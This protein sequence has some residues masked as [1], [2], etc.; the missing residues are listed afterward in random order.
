M[1]TITKSFTFVAAQPEVAVQVQKNFQEL[2]DFINSSVATVDSA[3]AYTACPTLPAT[4]PTT[5]EQAARKTWFDKRLRWQAVGAANYYGA[6]T[7]TTA[8]AHRIIMGGYQG[9]TDSAGRI[10]IPYGTTLSKVLTI[11][12]Q[13]QNFTGGSPLADQYMDAATVSN[14]RVN[15]STAMASRVVKVNFLVIGIV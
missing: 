14:F 6:G 4:D 13:L 8:D 7:P 11:V 2:I 15:L 3:K 5:I 12:F 9:T 10:T 1:A